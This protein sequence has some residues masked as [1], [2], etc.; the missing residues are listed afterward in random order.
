MDAERP[1]NR[2]FQNF[3]AIALAIAVRATQVDVA[4]E[5]HFHMLKAG[6]AAGGAAAVAV[7]EAEF[8]RGVATLARQGR[9]GKNLADGIPGP[10]IAHRV[11]TG[12]L[13][14]RRLVH[15]HHI[16][17][18]FR[19]QQALKGARRVGRLAKVPFERGCQDVLDQGRLTGT[20]DTGDA[21]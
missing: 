4:Q 14:N 3:R 20:A 1:L 12:R 5:L 19:A 10:H 8:G 11:G 9:R 7:V 2:D 6:A 18:L 17:E 21:H 16:A 13:A 15:K